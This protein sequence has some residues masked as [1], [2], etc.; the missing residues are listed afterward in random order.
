M[1]H[2]STARS[3]MGQFKVERVS[4]NPFIR[5]EI[6]HLSVSNR[7]DLE[8]EVLE[9]VVIH[10]MIHYLLHYRNIKDSSSHGIQF[11]KLM[12]EINRKHRRHISVSH[13]CSK[14]E[15][16]SDTA[17][18]HSIVCLCTMTDGR[19]LVCR[20][21]QSKVFEI[22]RAFKEWDKV[23]LEEWFW[24]YGSYFN[25]Y[26]RVLTPR[27]FSVDNEGLAVIS[28]GTRLVFTEVS[29]GRTILCPAGRIE[30]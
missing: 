21:S 3:F 9:D 7:Y 13:R 28:A 30:R 22:H 8:M 23:A 24:V 6:Y 18:A 4:R 16:A 25:R 1:L 14:E 2:I 19:K 26:R 10:E 27:L 29:G 17:K 5:K 11:R 20:V 15:L 12:K